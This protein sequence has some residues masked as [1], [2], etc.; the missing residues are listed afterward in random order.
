[1]TV[2]L[3]VV[4]SAVVAAM[5]AMARLVNWVLD[6]DSNLVQ[7]RKTINSIRVHLRAQ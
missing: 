2:E 6:F 5:M 4:K 7:L 1:M 3:S